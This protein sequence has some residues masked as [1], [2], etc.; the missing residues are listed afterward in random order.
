MIF[1]LQNHDQVGNRPFGHRLHHQIDPALFRALSALLLFAPETPLLFMGQEWAASSP[2]LFFTD[3]N[4]ELGRLVTE[5]RRHEFSRFRAFA[6]AATRARIPDPQAASTFDASRLDWEEC[7]RAPH[8][9]MLEL[10]RALLRLR[11]TEKALAAG[12]SCHIVELDDDGMALARTDTT[13]GSLLL[14]AWLGGSG[15]Y[16]YDRHGPIIPGERWTLVLSTEEPRFRS[17]GQSSTWGADM[18]A[19]GPLVVT[20]EG[21]AAVI[22]RRE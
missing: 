6:D 3:H 19:G 22:L 8:V 18:A 12:T 16:E 4:R 11:S 20:F 9:G 14:V 5:G 1:C 17:S 13:G 15:A 7:V 2:F 21:P 10:Y